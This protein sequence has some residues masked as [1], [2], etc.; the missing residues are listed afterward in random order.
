M[1]RAWSWLPVLRSC[2][3]TS[4]SLARWALV[5]TAR[6]PRLVLTMTCPLPS[7]PTT[8]PCK[9]VPEGRRETSGGGLGTVACTPDGALAASAPEL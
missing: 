3:T 2:R 6:V 7:A 8:T 4:L 5:A 9:V 1:I